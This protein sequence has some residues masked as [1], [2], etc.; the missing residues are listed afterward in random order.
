[1]F[2][3]NS[4]WV[5]VEFVDVVSSPENSADGLGFFLPLPQMGAANPEVTFGYP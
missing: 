2:P 3:G 5:R 4:V 1:M